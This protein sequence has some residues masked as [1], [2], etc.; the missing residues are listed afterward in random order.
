MLNRDV[1]MRICMITR[2]Y[3]NIEERKDGYAI[4]CYQL[5]KI[6]SNLKN[7]VYVLE[8]SKDYRKLTIGN[9]NFIHMKCPMRKSRDNFLNSVLTFHPFREFFF[10]LKSLKVL[11]SYRKIVS[12]SDLV[13]VEGFLIPFAVFLAR[14]LKKRVILDAHN[15][16]LLLALSYR[17][18]SKL[19]FFLRGIVYYFW[20]QLLI[21]LSDIIIVVS[22]RERDFVQRGYAIVR[23]KIFVV[24]NVIEI[25]RCGYS[26]QELASLRK[27]WNLES[28]VVVT[29]VG[30]L[31]SVQNRKAAEYIINDLAPYFRE[32]RKD[33]V[34]LIIGKGN[35]NVKCALPNVIF[36]GFT[37]D[38]APLL[39]ISDVCIAPLRVG[40]G[41][42]TKVLTY[43][44]Y[45]KLI[46]ATPIAMEGISIYG[47][48]SVIV[49]NISGFAEALSRA[50]ESLSI[51]NKE[52]IKNMEIIEKYYSSKVLRRKMKDFLDRIYGMS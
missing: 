30:N 27:K 41:T 33:A 3:E 19:V 12:T 10:Q 47:S 40:S 13:L 31:K 18:V 46:V 8:F 4:R 39:A 6:L 5:A 22:E 45:G 1:Y 51:L 20:E 37:K 11:Y 29:F 34:F 52:G 23:S 43:M 14:S 16:N 9:I 35:K 25:Q 2:S 21:R 42:K 48:K 38:L 49:S 15:V 36:T 17:K 32:K 28:K 44:A 50:I 7:T 24:P 26:R